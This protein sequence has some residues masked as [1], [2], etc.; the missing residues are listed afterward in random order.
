MSGKWFS[1][2]KTYTKLLNH[3][4][5]NYRFQEWNNLSN[6]NESPVA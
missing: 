3:Y 5:K 6:S 2:F 1:L 4:R